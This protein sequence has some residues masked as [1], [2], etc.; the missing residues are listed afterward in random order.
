MLQLNWIYKY[1]TSDHGLQVRALPG[2]DQVPEP[3]RRRL[4]RPKNGEQKS[5][6]SVCYRVLQFYSTYYQHMC[7]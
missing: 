7:G 5:L 2:A 4:R 3:I 1:L 6:L